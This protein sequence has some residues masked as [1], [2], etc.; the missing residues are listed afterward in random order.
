M[1]YSLLLDQIVYTSFAQTGFRTVASKQVPAEI[2]QAFMERVVHQH[3]NSYKPPQA[4]YR[5]VYL[6]QVTPEQNLFGWLYNDGADDLERKDVPYF[7]CYYL[8]EPLLFYFQLEKIL[9]CLH[10]GPVGEIDRHIPQP[11]LETVVVRNFWSY[12]SVRPGV[13]IP[14]V[15]RAHSHIALKQGELLDLFLP[16]DQQ[17]QIIELN[18]QT[19]E[20]QIENLAIYTRYLVKAAETGTV[21]LNED[22]NAIKARVIQPYRGYKEN[23]QRYEQAFV[24]AIQRE[25]QLTEDTRNSLKRLQQVLQLRNED[26]EQIEARSHR[27][28]I[29]SSPNKS[30]KHISALY[31]YRN[32]QYLLTA[33]IFTMILVLFGLVYETAQM[34]L[35]APNLKDLSPLET[36][37]R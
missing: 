11:T 3:W 36:R 10:K 23:L 19:H 2:Q 25:Y 16:L 32:P 18:A 34:Q 27:V 5:A 20:Q 22:V 13:A 15:V 30:A 17:E 31:A 12:Q 29:P 28:T 1:P 35:F 6:H 14:A 21:A 33:G 24:S 9:S 37:G 26:I 4:G 8:A 7:I